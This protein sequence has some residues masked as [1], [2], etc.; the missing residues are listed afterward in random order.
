MQL[1]NAIRKRPLL[2]TGILGGIVVLLAALV[3]VASY[4]AFPDQVFKPGRDDSMELAEGQDIS[5][6]SRFDKA[7]YHIGERIHQQLQIIYR[8]DQVVPDM[9]SL[10]RRMSFFPFEQ[11]AVSESV[12]E[13]DDNIVEHTLD[14]ELQGVRVDLQES[15]QI[16]PFILYYSAADS[17]DDNV[18]SQMIQPPPVH[19]SAYYPDNVLDVNL[20]TIR[21]PLDTAGPLRQSLMVGAAVILILLIV[22]TLWYYGRRRKVNELSEEERLWRVFHSMDSTQLDNRTALLNYEQ[23]MTHLI[24]HQTGVSPESFWSGQNPEDE[25]WREI[26]IQARRCLLENYQPEPPTD[27]SIICMKDLL[28]QRLSSLVTEKRLQ[29]EQGPT[30]S[31]RIRQQ[32]G[33]LTQTGIMLAVALLLLGLAVMPGTWV[34]NELKQYNEVLANLEAGTA[35]NE[36]TYLALSA[37]G[38]SAK[39]GTVKSAALYNAGTLRADNAFSM[40]NRAQEQLVL[41]AALGSATVED[42]FH[43]LFED[44]PFDEETQIVSV[45]VDGAE[46]LRRAQLDLQS[47]V[48]VDPADV[49]A[50]RNLEVSL[51]RRS[52]VLAMLGQIRNFYRAQREGEEDEALSDEGII[53]LLES[54]LPEDEEEENTGKNDRGYMILE[55]F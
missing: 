15:Y 18:F 17:N 10:R 39:T 14:F 35:G 32:P 29:I 55:R 30:Y 16:D 37:M 21:N 43:A 8:K 33:V 2:I 42:L 50:Q 25:E 5:G 23:V 40:S 45:L 38:D 11:L 22:W 26:A 13:H 7:S 31:Q 36:E 4:L 3:I 1:L 48:R 41:R 54:Q 53:N 6:W 12:I 49:D 34:S 19:I 9:D 46:Q 47:A 27:A 44:G 51:K 20:Q 52:T 24:Y 28:N